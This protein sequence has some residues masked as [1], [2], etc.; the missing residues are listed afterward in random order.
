LDLSIIDEIPPGRPPVISRLV[1][2][3]KRGEIF[4]WL[5]ER[6]G[7]G[8]RAFLIFPLIEESD[9][10]EL[11]AA[12][13][14]FEVLSKGELAGISCELLHGRMNGARKAEIM[15]RFA[16][17]ET[18]ILVAT[19]VIEVGIDVPEATVMLIHN[20]ERFGLSQLHQ[21]RG[22]I[23][24]GEKKSYCLL[25]MPDGV[26]EAANRRLKLFV[27]QRDGFRLAE[28]D[29][30]ERGP[31]DFFGVRQHGR[32]ELRL[33]H[34]LDDAALVTLARDRARSLVEQD[35]ELLAGD[36]RALRSLLS[37]LFVDRIF[38]SGVG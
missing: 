11:S 24:R 3:T 38:L 34:P 26:G 8:E 29:L 9:K 35:P 16:S 22:R 32:P 18:R 23:G 14:E 25:L 36:L 12:T 37:R 4:E 5:R 6:V 13:E 1:G 15:E 7:T 21:L 20:P 28:E 2:E 33:V 27:A 30:K 10:L 17:G 31:G 19:T